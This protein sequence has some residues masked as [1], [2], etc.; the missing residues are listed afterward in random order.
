MRYR[1]TVRGA[2]AHAGEIWYREEWRSE[3]EVEVEGSAALL[4]AGL[5]CDETSIRNERNE[6]RVKL[7]HHHLG[8]LCKRGEVKHLSARRLE[9]ANT[10]PGNAPAR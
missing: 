4:G 2:S 1:E 10:S 8:V 7:A 9:T 5:R 3:S 6:Q